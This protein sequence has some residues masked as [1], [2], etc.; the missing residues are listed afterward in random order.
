MFVGM[1]IMTILE[2]LELLFFSIVAAPFLLFRFSALPCVRPA[3]EDADG[4]QEEGGPPAGPS[5]EAIL[6]RIAAITR[7]RK[8]AQVR[9][10]M[11]V[12]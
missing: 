11:T 12:R 10:N 7:R 3:E 2:W 9:G 1:S 8:A 5:D 6:A 4:G